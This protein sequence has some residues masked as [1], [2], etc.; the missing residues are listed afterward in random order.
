M[1]AERSDQLHGEK[2]ECEA[3]ANTNCWNRRIQSVPTIRLSCEFDNGLNNLLERKKRWQP[4]NRHTFTTRGLVTCAVSPTTL[5]RP[6]DQNHQATL[7]FRAQTRLA[8]FRP[9]FCLHS[10]SF[11][12]LLPRIDHQTPLR[13]GLISPFASLVLYSSASLRRRVKDAVI[14]SAT[15]AAP[16]S[17]CSFQRSGASRGLA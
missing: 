2:G 7:S 8:F 3:D 10:S 6:A 9:V 17:F 11:A 15:M 1:G 13:P 16:R 4:I 5:R 14:L 12:A